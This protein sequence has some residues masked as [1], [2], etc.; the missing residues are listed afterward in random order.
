MR[1][2]HLSRVSC[3]ITLWERI[4][5]IVIWRRQSHLL[6]LRR[7]TPVLRRLA[8]VEPSNGKQILSA[9]IAPIL[10]KDA[11]NANLRDVIVLENLR[12]V[13]VLEKKAFARRDK[14]VDH[15]RK[16]HK[17]TWDEWRDFHLIAPITTNL[18]VQ[19]IASEF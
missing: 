13:I 3:R 8:S 10:E 6:S 5:I 2:L 18:E 1:S 9:T 14:L 4:P 19:N 15:Q 7:N 12:D 17:A 11:S 16:I